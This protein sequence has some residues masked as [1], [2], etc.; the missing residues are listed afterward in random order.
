MV[1]SKVYNVKSNC[2]ML[3]VIVVLNRKEKPLMMTSSI[4][5]YPHI[6]IVF[7][8]FNLNCH[9]KVTGLKIS[10]KDKFRILTNHIRIHT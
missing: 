4:C 1:L 6:K 9:I 8:I 10:I 3:V 2:F 7:K 5:I